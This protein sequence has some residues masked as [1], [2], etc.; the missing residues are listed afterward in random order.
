MT[1]LR[2]LEHAGETV[3]CRHCGKELAADGSR[4]FLDDDPNEGTFGGYT[5][6]VAGTTFDN[7]IEEIVLC[8]SCDNEYIKAKRTATRTAAET[9]DEKYVGRSPQR[10]WR[11]TPEARNRYCPICHKWIP[12]GEAK[13]RIDLHGKK[14]ATRTMVICGPCQIRLMKG[15]PHEDQ[16]HY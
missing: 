14:E 3:R 2:D 11:L 6:Y 9:A 1:L 5:L 16:H 4:P 13:A 10:L 12:I 7:D 15:E 8:A